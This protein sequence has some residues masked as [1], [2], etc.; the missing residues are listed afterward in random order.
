MPNVDDANPLGRYLRT[1]RSLVPPDVVGLSDMGNRR[2]PGLRREEV[3][4]LAGISSDYYVR[5]EQGRDRHPSEQVLRSIARALQLDEEATGYLIKIAKPKGPGRKRPRKPERV[6]D[7]IHTLINS[8]PLTAAYVHG[9]YMD[10]LAANS[11]AI[12]LSPYNAPGQNGILAAFLEPEMRELY[13]DWDEMT[14]RVVP[15]LRSI[16]GADMEES[17][18]VELVGALSLRSERFRKLWA[19]QDVTHKTTGTSKLNHPQVGSLELHYEKLLIPGTDLQ[20]LITYHANPGSE[21]EERLRLLAAMDTPFD[22][23]RGA[24]GNRVG[25]DSNTPP[26]VT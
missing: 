16:V 3:A 20:A 9:K 15:Y 5:L 23:S 25:P 4:F 22:P 19:R 11:L 21:S 26:Q 1:R 2:V 24:D 18:L 8:W 7:G 10:V 12:A 14:A 13:A 6:S 17:R